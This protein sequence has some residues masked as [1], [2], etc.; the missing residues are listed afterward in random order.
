M[1]NLEI[2]DIQIGFDGTN[3]NLKEKKL[4]DNYRYKFYQKHKIIDKYHPTDNSIL[5]AITNQKFNSY[6]KDILSNKPINFIKIF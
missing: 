2:N 4:N 6:L 3:I 1:P 5:P